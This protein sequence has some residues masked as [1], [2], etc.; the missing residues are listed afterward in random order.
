MDGALVFNSRVDPQQFRWEPPGDGEVLAHMEVAAPVHRSQEFP[1]VDVG[2]LFIYG[3]SAAGGLGKER[4]AIVAREIENMLFCVKKYALVKCS[5]SEDM[6]M[7][8]HMV[9]QEL[10]PALEASLPLRDWIEWF[11][12][13]APVQHLA[14][15]LRKPVWRPQPMRGEE[16]DDN[17]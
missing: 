1:E 3:V 14:F 17:E 12:S 11:C 8:F 5:S 6:R 16:E 13:K 2:I 7:A 15:V 4:E 10:F 9:I